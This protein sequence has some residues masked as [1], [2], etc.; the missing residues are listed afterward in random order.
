MEHVTTHTSVLTILCIGFE[1]Y[2]AI[3]SPLLVLYR[4]TKARAYRVIACVWLVSL[5][6][7]LPFIFMTETMEDEFY[8]GKSIVLVCRTALD[9]TWKHIYAIAIIVL[10]F[11]VPLVVLV[12]IYAIV[13]RKLTQRNH[14]LDMPTT[15]KQVRNIK[16]FLYN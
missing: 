1:R 12:V 11:T 2:Y 6:S 5:I 10:F 7:A 14:V 9:S 15:Q 8:D 4:C 3:C 13:T 16:R